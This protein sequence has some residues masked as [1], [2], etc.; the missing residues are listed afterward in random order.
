MYEH[1][2]T[3]APGGRVNVP[4]SSNVEAV[5]KPA[6]NFYRDILATES[7]LKYK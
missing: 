6:D 7:A 4:P 1:L 3:R 2:T 5:E